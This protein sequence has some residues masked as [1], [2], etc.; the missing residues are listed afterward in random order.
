[1]AETTAPAAP[2]TPSPSDP[3][4]SRIRSIAAG[5]CLV[6]GFLLL[7]G[8]VVSFWGQKTLTNTEQ[9]VATVAPL[10][11]EIAIKEAV[12]EAVSKAIVKNI[13]VEEY[14]VDTLGERAAPLAMPIEGAIA[15]FIDRVALNL[16]N[17][18][19]FNTLWAAAT[20]RLQENLIAV[21]EGDRG[22]AVTL[23][24][25][26]IVLDLTVAIEAVQKA[27]VERGFTPAANLTI[28][29]QADRQIVL[30]DGS[31]VAEAQQI[32]GFAKPMASVWIFI[33][34][35]LLIV[36]VALAYN[37]ARMTVWVGAAILV[38]G[39]L[40]ITG[41]GVGNTA[42][43]NGFAGN[44]FEAAGEVFYAQ[45]TF[46]LNNSAVWTIILGVL[47]IVIGWLISNQRGAV[48]I[49]EKATTSNPLS[50]GYTP[51]DD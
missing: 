32:Y 9:F 8:G 44:P 11:E 33:A 47:V 50:S 21:L 24:G 15:S 28:P 38:T 6:L 39:I 31:Q 1:M 26:E 46:A 22:G 40:L 51:K 13:P 25:D 45:L 2:A 37:R 48:A 16:M 4:R 17:R 34:I 19:E 30:M 12:A 29:D 23:Q 3:R 27:L 7:P 42:L 35:G 36:A 41:L 49:R 10:S 20:E 14:L 43:S 18:P 5:L